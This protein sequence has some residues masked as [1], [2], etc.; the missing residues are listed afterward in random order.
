MQSGPFPPYIP[1]MTGEVHGPKEFYATPAG[2]VAARLLRER[3]HALW[4][5][6]SG[7][8]VLGLGY[9]APYLRL[10]REEA[11]R[12]VALTPCHHGAVRWPPGNSACATLVAEEDALPF[13]DLS[14]DRVLLVHGLE[15]A[16]NARRLLRETWR[17]LRDDGRL[18][19]VVPNRN[20]IWAHLER[21]PFGHG[22]PYTTGQLARLLERHLFRV[23]R[24]DAAL[25]VPPVGLRLLLRTANLWERVGLSLCPR[26]G[27][28][29][30]VEA[31]K[32]VLAAIPAGAVAV[33]RRVL[34]A[35]P[36][37]G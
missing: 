28:L 6:L 16:E 13:P 20:G 15:G 2:R 14:F 23:E 5:D 12:C 7:R 1:G 22:Q 21:T 10:W 9:T 36:A 35:E 37:A 11:Q 31:E 25:F 27:G 19:A 33:P 8:S 30:I 29:A 17:V 4:P 26:V 24:R 18:L 34:A 3:L 32:D